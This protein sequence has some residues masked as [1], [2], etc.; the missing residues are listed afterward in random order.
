M[1]AWGAGVSESS[2]VR[3]THHI[4]IGAVAIS[5]TACLIKPD[6]PE[7]DCLIE[8]DQPTLWV[9]RSPAL[10]IPDEDVDGVTDAVQ[11]DSPCVLD[12]IEICVDIPHDWRGDVFITIGTPD[13]SRIILKEDEGDGPEDPEDDVLEIFPTTQAPVGNLEGLQG[14][15]GS[16]SWTLNVA[17]L[18]SEDYGTLAAWSISL[19]CQ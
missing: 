11:V 18:E 8:P 12:S 1:L 9:S 7:I 16:G 2:E 13:M 5:A 14:R 6:E 3:V 10:P 17:D 15:E 19:Y 4:L